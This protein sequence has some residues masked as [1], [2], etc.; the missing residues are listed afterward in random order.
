MTRPDIAPHTL[1]QAN[2]GGG[3]APPADVAADPE[4]LEMWRTLATQRATAVDSRQQ[5]YEL[6]GC[7]RT[8]LFLCSHPA[9]EDEVT[10]ADNVVGDVSYVRAGVESA[11]RCDPALQSAPTPL[12]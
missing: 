11:V 8:T 7:G 3:E 9:S 10:G 6:Q 4:R 1:Q 12:P 2:G 5:T